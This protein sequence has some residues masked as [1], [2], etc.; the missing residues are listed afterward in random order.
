MCIRIRGKAPA[1]IPHPS[2]TLGKK[3]P[4]GIIL[5]SK[6]MQQPDFIE[7]STKAMAPEAT[8]EDKNALFSAFLDL[9][10]WIFIS[11]NVSDLTQVTPFVSEIDGRRWIFA[12]TDSTLARRFGE[13]NHDQV[14]GGFLT[15]SGDILFITMTVPQAL[16]YLKRLDESGTVFGLQVNFGMPGWFV[17][18]AGL[19]RIIAHHGWNAGHRAEG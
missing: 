19:P 3:S 11:R 8:I 14:E 9:K 10:A 13:M 5:P 15:E 2:L 7:L 6:T 12:F 17:P 16:E 4:K 1:P 18:L